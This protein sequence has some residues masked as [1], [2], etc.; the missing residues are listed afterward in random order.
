MIAA[1]G[2]DMSTLEQRNART[3]ASAQEAYDNRAEPEYDEDEDWVPRTKA[4]RWVIT[5]RYDWMLG[6]EH[7]NDEPED[8][9]CSCRAAKNAFMAG[10]AQRKE[11]DPSC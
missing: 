7:P 11:E 5:D 4:P 6:Y 9:E 2:D 8:W 3:L 1:Q 10:R